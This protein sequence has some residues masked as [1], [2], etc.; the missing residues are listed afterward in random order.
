MNTLIGYM[1]NPLLNDD[2]IGFLVGERLRD[3]VANTPSITIRELGGSAFA[4]LTTIEPFDKVIII[5]AVV[6]KQEMGT[7]LVYSKEEI[8]SAAKTFY[9]HGMNLSEAFVLA[10]RLGMTLPEKISLIGID[11]GGDKFT[12]YIDNTRLGSFGGK[13]SDGLKG[14]LDEITGKVWGAVTELLKEPPMAPNEG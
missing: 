2:C 5:D 11:I 13:L 10:K 6:A 1:G 14:K 8:E 4:F 3:F 12:N 7:V 9:L